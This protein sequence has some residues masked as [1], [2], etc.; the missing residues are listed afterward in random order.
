MK[1]LL[2]VMTA[3]IT[4]KSISQETRR[5]NKKTFKITVTDSNQIPQK[6]FLLSV[7]DSNLVMVTSPLK[8]DDEVTGVKGK[9]YA[10]EDVSAITISRKGAVGRGILIGSITGALV[11]TIVGAIT[12]K[13]PPP[14]DPQNIFCIN[15]DFGAGFDALAGGAVGM[16]GGGVI[17]AV[18]G[19]VA[20][21]T[22]I[23]GGRRE[24]FK[25]FQ[26]NVL[27]KAYGNSK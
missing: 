24:D 10:F 7:S 3:L 20:R 16:L 25:K 27:D 6:G 17:G 22:F 14:C 2:L 1:I 21:K 19:S 18:L 5:V 9:S 12:Y 13:K 23:I 4:L 8:F 26:I 11:G 15:L